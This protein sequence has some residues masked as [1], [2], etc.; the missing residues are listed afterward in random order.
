MSAILAK[1]LNSTVG[2]STITPLDTLLGTVANNAADRLYTKLKADVKLVGSDDVLYTYTGGYTHYSDYSGNKG[3][4]WMGAAFECRMS[5]YI[6]FSASGT[7]TVK[8]SV[9]NTQ[10]ASMSS[11]LQ[12]RNSSGVI[13][14]DDYFSCSGNSATTF[15]FDMNVTAGTKYMIGYANDSGAASSSYVKPVTL[16]ICATPVLFGATTTL[17]TS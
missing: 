12:V 2:S 17:S 7:V 8:L 14:Y 11:R 15:S 9:R 5:S 1:I 16:D 6:S 13:I 10:G 4:S 3:D